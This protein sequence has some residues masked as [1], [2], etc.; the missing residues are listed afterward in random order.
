MERATLGRMQ[1]PVR[2]ILHGS[3]ALAS[4]VGLVYLI[5]RTARDAATMWSVV[6]F[7]VSLIALYTT[8]SL[9]HSVPWS[10]AWKS[11]FQRLDHS[12][13]LVLVAGSW[14]PVAVNALDGTWRVVTLAIVWIAA[15]VGVVQKLAWPQIRVWFTITLAT[16]MGWFA[17]VPLREIAASLAT[18]ALFLMFLG[19]LFY[20]SGMIIWATK[21]PRLF[22][23]V[24]SYH[25]VFHV[26]VVAGSAVHFV[27]IAA[28]VVPIAA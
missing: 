23:R 17:L 15:V 4:A 7:G 20:T 25:E 27:M 22:P 1:N 13:I 21:R 12:M 10:A 18:E 24:F 11:R 9:Y 8:S 26:L 28:Y 19:G 16:A 3:A 6:V 2:G 14:T 5:S